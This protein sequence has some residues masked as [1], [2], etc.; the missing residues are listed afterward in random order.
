MEV[1]PSKTSPIQKHNLSSTFHE[2]HEDKTRHRILDSKR[3][4]SDAV[5][6]QG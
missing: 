1:E 6:T 5:H 3:L 4:K 2:L